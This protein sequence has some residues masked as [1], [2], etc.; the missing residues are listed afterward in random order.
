MGRKFR[1]CGLSPQTAWNL[2]TGRKSQD[3]KTLRKQLKADLSWPCLAWR[4]E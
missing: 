3:A 2:T 4:S 1:T